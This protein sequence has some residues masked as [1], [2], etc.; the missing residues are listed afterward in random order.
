[1]SSRNQDY[2]AGIVLG[3]VDDQNNL[4]LMGVD[5]TKWRDLGRF[6]TT[7]DQGFLSIWFEWPES[8]ALTP[9]GTNYQ[10]IIIRGDV[11]YP[12]ETGQL[13][14]YNSNA[15]AGE[16]WYAI[17]DPV[18]IDVNANTYNNIEVTFDQEDLTYYCNDATI[19]S[20]SV[21]GYDWAIIL[22][23]IC[24]SEPSCWKGVDIFTLEKRAKISNGFDYLK[25]I[26]PGLYLPEMQSKPSNMREL[27]SEIRYDPAI[28][29]NTNWVFGE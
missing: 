14:M 18:A 22:H 9:Q 29:N 23:Y 11:N 3:F 15:A 1:M 19:G 28:I 13:F 24:S 27:S 2:L 25:Q 5:G 21:T 20:L 17:T 10:F 7:P 26:I 12:D 4:I 6:E 8:R 16:G